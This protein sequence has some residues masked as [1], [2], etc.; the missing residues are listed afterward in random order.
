[1]FDFKTA[2]NAVDRRIIIKILA[3]DGIKSRF[4]V[5][6]YSR[7]RDFKGILGQECQLSLILFYLFI[8]DIDKTWIKRKF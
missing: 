4:L 3:K 2:V 8:E 1:M 7:R 6:S 5:R